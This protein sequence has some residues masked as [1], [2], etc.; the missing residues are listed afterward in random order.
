MIVRL[1]TESD[2]PVI[3]N[4]I[5]EYVNDGTLLPRTVE[6][7]YRSLPSLLVADVEGQ[8]AGVVALHRLDHNV[9]EVRTLTVAK[10]YQGQGIGQLLVQYA[11]NL[12]EERGYHK[13]ISFTTQ[14]E[15]FSRCGFAPIARD[16]VPTKYYLDCVHCSKLFRC[17]ETA[18]ERILVSSAV[19]S[20]RVSRI[21]KRHGQQVI[22]VSECEPEAEAIQE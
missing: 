12:A 15:F 11:I 20:P 19:E 6:S 4:L 1:A 16:S 21:V 7:L 5:Q 9:A 13:V 10:G 3:H 8:L 18:M 22:V 2:V 17:D 14:I